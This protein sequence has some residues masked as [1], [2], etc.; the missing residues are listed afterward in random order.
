[1]NGSDQG[2]HL[3]AEVL[4]LQREN[5]AL[6]QQQAADAAALTS[7]RASVQALETTNRRL[8]DELVTAQ[9]QLATLAQTLAATQQQLAAVQQ[10]LAA[11][12]LPPPTPAPAWVKPN[13]APRPK[14]E[15]RKRAPQHNR[16]RRRETPTR[17]EAHRLAACPD[18]GHGLEPQRLVRT[19][20]V[21]EIPPPPPVEVIEHQL[22]AGYCPQCHTWHQPPFDLSGQVLGQERIGLRLTSLIATLRYQAR[23]PFQLIQALLHDLWG[24]TLSLGGIIGVL[25]RVRQATQAAYEALLAQARGSPVLHMDETGWRE[26]GDNGYIWELA[27]A[28]ATPVRIYVY[29]GSRA[30]AVRAAVLG[31]KFAGVLICDFYAAYNGYTGRIQRCWVH[32]LRDLHELKQKHGNVTGVPEWAAA[33]AKLYRVG[34]SFVQQRPA[35]EAAARAGKAAELE[36][37]AAAL[38]RQYAQQGEHPCHALAQRL[39]RHQDELF[40]FVRVPGVPADNNLAERGLRPLV[41]ARKISGGSRSA[42]GS[43]IHM[44]LASLIGTW[45]A[46]GQNPFVELLALLR[47]S[48]TSQ[49]TPTGV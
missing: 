3:R 24:V 16:A 2:R 9:S 39:L 18:C 40:V 12:T 27:T 41:V 37:Q 43:S 5:Q 33:V 10:H 19:R 22:W 8:R 44:Q 48:P 32:L 38:G 17:V 47:P 35:P 14:R 46:R 45:L 42:D 30:G 25:K 29:D 36:A 13:T 21:V 28:G 20:Q 23:L 11:T 4:R 6:R 15:R 7:L 31:G 1:M 49:A 26:N 34:Q